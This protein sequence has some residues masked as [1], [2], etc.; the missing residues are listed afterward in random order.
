[1]NILITGGAGYIGTQLTKALLARG[2]KVTI[3]DLFWFGDFL[4]EH[5]NLTKIRGDAREIKNISIGNFDAIFHFASVANDPCTHLD[6]ALGWDISVQSSFQLADHALRSRVPRIIY[7]SSGSVYGVKNEEKVTENLELVPISVYN[8]AKIAAERIFLSYQDDINIQ[9]VRPATVCG[10]SERMRLDVAVNLLTIQALTN[11]EITVLGGDQFRPNIHILDLVSTY[12]HLLDN[13]NLNGIYNAGFEN[14]TI[15]DLA[16]KISDITK[17]EI[18]HENS[19]DPRSYR[20]DSSKLIKTGFTPKYNVEYAINEIAQLYKNGTLKNRDV[21][22][23]V[24]WMR[25]LF[26]EKVL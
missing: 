20:I 10:Y 25:S 6:P 23:N 24:N 15:N 7:A 2:Y 17:A 19:N 5:K 22:Y 26:S 13:P 9:I 16:K 3:L 1:M 8:K 12:L 21:F 14:I 18:K 4:G 11:N